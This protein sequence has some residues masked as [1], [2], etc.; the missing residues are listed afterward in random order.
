MTQTRSGVGRHSITSSARCWRRKCTSRPSALAVL[1]LITSSLDYLV[2]AGDQARRD[3]QA[4]S[5]GGLQVD[6][7]LECGRQLDGQVGGLGTLENAVDIA[8][9]ALETQPQI[10]A[11][12]DE[13]PG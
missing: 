10:C 2:G 6:D 8:R 5:G 1:R 3:G 12:E 4:D 13:D 7:Q 9:R 11:K